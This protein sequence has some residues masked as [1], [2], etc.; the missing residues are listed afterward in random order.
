MI[1]IVHVTATT[2]AI[3]ENALVCQYRAHKETVGSVVLAAAAG[4]RSSVRDAVL[5]DG[6][7]TSKAISDDKMGDDKTT[8]LCCDKS[9]PSRS[10]SPAHATACNN[11]NTVSLR[12]R[13]HEDFS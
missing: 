2:T 4:P 7:I 11:V 9:A 6:M 5:K 13:V 1:D 10:V 12:L 3:N 8:E